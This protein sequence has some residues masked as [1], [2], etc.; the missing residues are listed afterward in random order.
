MDWKEA[1]IGFEGDGLKLG[2]LKIWGTKWRG[3]GA[4]ALLPHPAHKS[5]QHSFHVY[6]IGPVEDPIRFAAC[7]LSNGVWGFY[8]PA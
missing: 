5:E 1:H 8:L 3:T 2:G 4:G 7:E 6:E